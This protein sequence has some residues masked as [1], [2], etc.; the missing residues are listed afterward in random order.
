MMKRLL[1][2][3]LS[4]LFFP[5]VVDAAIININY[6]GYVSATEGAGLGYTVGD[7]VTGHI[8]IDL[9]KALGVTAQSGNVANYYTASDQHNLI[10]GY[11]TGERGNSADTVDFYDAAHEYG[12]TYED[13][14]KVSDSDS[15]FLLDANYNFTSNF[16]SFYLEVLLPGIDWLDI[17]SLQNMNI[18]ITDPAL[19]AA[20]R[21]QMYNVFAS[22]NASNYS[23]Y[24][25]VAYITLGSLT[26]SATDTPEDNIVTTVPETSSLWLLIVGIAGLLLG[27]S[28]SKASMRD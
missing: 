16:Y 15:E 11:H 3:G 20:S 14:L 26:V 7:G 24:A 27:C 4:A 18:N 2:F 10:S 8:Q 17:N 22:G 9:S 21:A 25:D 23:V 13:L 1:S 28:R 5:A 19:L 12:A 6:T